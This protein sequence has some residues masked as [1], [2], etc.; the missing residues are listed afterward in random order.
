MTLHNG[1]PDGGDGAGGGFGS[2]A[3]AS[4]LPMQTA[5]T[6]AATII[7]FFVIKRSLS[8]RSPNFA[9]NFALARPLELATAG[10]LTGRLQQLD[11]EAQ[12]TEL[13]TAVF[14]DLV[15]APRR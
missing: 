6:Q 4:P 2:S 8:V 12:R 9:A 13:V 7:N 14:G 11:S 15:R 1:P 3:Y 10:D 5:A